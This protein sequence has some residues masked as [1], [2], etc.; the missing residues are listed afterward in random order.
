[1]QQPTLKIVGWTWFANLWLCVV[2]GCGSLPQSPNG[3]V[4]STLPGKHVGQQLSAEQVTPS[5]SPTEP[6]PPR[7]LFDYPIGRW[8]QSDK[9][10]P[11]N[12][13]VWAS[14]L[15]QLA[16]AEF[17][18]DQKVTIRNVRNAEWLTDTDCLVDY[19]DKTY[20]LRDLQTV[21]FIM[22]PFNNNRS[23]AHTMLSFGFGKGDYVGI[24]VEVRKELGEQY[25]AGLGLARQ[26]E[27]IYVVADERDLLPVRVKQRASDV[28]IYRATTSPEKVRAMFVDMLSRANQLAAYPEFYD[29]V[30]NNCTTNIVRHVNH[31]TPGRVPYDYRVL[32]PGYSDQLAYELGLIDNRLPFTELRRRARANER[33]VKYEHDPDFSAKIRQ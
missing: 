19:Y 1:M 17:E 9:L 22:V 26:F 25:N 10:V 16:T 21:D 24:S 23:I 3:S 14:D 28:F 32:L 15:A 29:T 4:V 11:S 12:D 33:I 20:D 5:P 18:D 7:P 30:T 2:V 8:L 31:L 6:S 27:L 13:R